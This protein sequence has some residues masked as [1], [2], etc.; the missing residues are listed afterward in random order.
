MSAGL[1]FELFKKEVRIVCKTGASGFLAGRAL[2]QEAPQIRSRA[3]R[4]RFLE[5]TAVQR[6]KQLTEVA[7]TYGTPWFSKLGAEKGKFAPVGED[8]YESY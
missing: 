3:E 7:N 2:W 6:L 5:T 4:T 1:D 8:W